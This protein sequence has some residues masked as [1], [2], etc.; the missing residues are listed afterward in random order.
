MSARLLGIV[1]VASISA[2]AAY[3]LFTKKVRIDFQRCQFISCLYFPQKEEEEDTEKGEPEVIK[4]TEEITDVEEPDNSQGANFILDKDRREDEEESNS[5]QES[6]TTSLY[7]VVTLNDVPKEEIENNRDGEERL[8]VKLNE[9]D[10]N[11][12]DENISNIL[13]ESPMN[14]QEE[15]TQA[16]QGK[17]N[18]SSQEIEPIEF[19]SD[20]KSGLSESMIIVE[21]DP[22]EKEK[23]L[24]FNESSEMRRITRGFL[25]NSQL[26]DE[27]NAEGE[28][29]GNNSVEVDE[30][31]E[32]EEEKSGKDESVSGLNSSFKVDLRPSWMVNKTSVKRMKEST[33]SI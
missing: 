6:L 22:E 4:D 15:L 32:P 31:I 5:N 28:D 27:D 19:L 3:L 1:A 26:E 2:I 10:L 13:D 12:E 7:E 18:D 30:K 21:N 16:E 23:N 14:I 9:D 11:T 29:D 17:K 25:N 8:D 20:D 33:A 24:S